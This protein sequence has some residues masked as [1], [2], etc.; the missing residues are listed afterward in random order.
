MPYGLLTVCANFPR[1]AL[2]DIDIRQHRP[3][4]LVSS[5]S[6][7]KRIADCDQPQRSPPADVVGVLLSN[8]EQS[9]ALSRTVLFF[10]LVV[11]TTFERSKSSWNR[12]E[13]RNETK[14]EGSPM[15][16]ENKRLGH[17]EE[18][19]PYLA[20]DTLSRWSRASRTCQMWELQYDRAPWRYPDFEP[21]PGEL[22]S[23]VRRG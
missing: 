3:P 14:S 10:N 23:S 12:Q 2:A 15:R 11:A 9:F 7:G 5:V 13:I 17:G 4:S 20:N 19:L 18:F 21:R 16:G 22:W 1:P 8:S 6:R